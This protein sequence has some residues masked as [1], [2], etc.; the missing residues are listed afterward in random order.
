MPSHHRYS[1]VSRIRIGVGAED[2]TLLRSTGIAV[3]I[4]DGRM[5]AIR[6]CN[7]V[8]KKSIGNA[9]GLIAGPSSLK[10]YNNFR[11]CTRYVNIVLDLKYLT[12][13][14]HIRYSELSGS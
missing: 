13:Y 12:T 11:Y 1:C 10:R 3:L 7:H 9:T 8:W 14:I 6:I 5:R 4:T 2:E